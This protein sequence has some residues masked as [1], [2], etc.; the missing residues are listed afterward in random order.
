M[1]NSLKH[2][3]L[4]LN[5]SGEIMLINL[6]AVSVLKRIGIHLVQGMSILDTALPNTIMKAARTAALLGQS[7]LDQKETIES[8]GNALHI[9]WNATPLNDKGTTI[10][11]II[12]FEDITES[13][14]LF[15]QVQDSERLAVAGEVAA[16][17]AHEIR[18]PLAV[19][20]GS[21]QLLEMIDDKVKQVEL[22][23]M[24]QGELKRMNVVLTDF[25]KTARPD[26]SEVSGEIEVR[27]FLREL[28]LL[29]KGEAHLH[30][31]LL[32]VL[33][34]PAECPTLLAKK[35]SLKQVCLN[36]AKNSFEAIDKGGS[37][38]ITSAWDENNSI[39]IFQD[40]GP[41]IPEENLGL[42]FRP[43]FTTK[44]TGTGLGLSVS[45]AIIK[46]MGGIIKV[47]SEAGQGT[48]VRVILPRAQS[49]TLQQ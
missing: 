48:T 49:K 14:N 17:L 30:D 43:F 1:I 25:L 33:L 8:D 19:A 9:R 44:L 12:I 11:S 23:K 13:V 21:L 18:N 46:S 38:I 41:G 16:G 3:V 32:Q 40:N 24:V 4:V 6:E 2:G 10:G 15:R 34:P 28:E 37:L 29:L 42:L 20:T 26:R 22:L 35:N 45:N 47:E 7:F 36:I 27:D 39:L 31:I 5:V